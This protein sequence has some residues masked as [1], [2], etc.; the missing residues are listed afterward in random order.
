MSNDRF[1]FGGVGGISTTLEDIGLAKGCY[2]TPKECPRRLR[3]ALPVMG[4]T[5]TR[6]FITRPPGAKDKAL[7][8]GMKLYSGGD[9]RIEARFKAP[10]GGG[11]VLGVILE[12]PT[13]GTPPLMEVRA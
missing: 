10:K 4:G 2:Q 12:V 7:H 1:P 11:H 3:K 5:Q 8:V 13:D 6:T 9:G